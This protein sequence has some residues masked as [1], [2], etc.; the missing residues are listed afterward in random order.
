MALPPALFSFKFGAPG[1]MI[2]AA[3]EIGA[4]SPVP[5]VRDRGRVAP[6][7]SL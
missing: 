6:A 2:A 4:G 5:P 7:S 3:S 1:Q